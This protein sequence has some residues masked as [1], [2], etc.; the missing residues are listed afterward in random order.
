MIFAILLLFL[1]WFDTHRIL[2]E[3]EEHEKSQ[4]D[5]FQNLYAGITLETS[6][7]QSYHDDEYDFSV[8]YP[9]TLIATS[10]CCKKRYGSG[11]DYSKIVAFNDRSSGKR[12]ATLTIILPG[13]QYPSAKDRIN[14]DTKHSQIGGVDAFFS[15]YYNR[16]G[17]VHEK[18]LYMLEVPSEHGILLLEK[19]GE[20]FRFSSATLN[21]L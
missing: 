13:T 5:Y 15:A 19:M 20:T 1:N 17:F 10:T 11:S 3:F 9:E 2:Q 6:K 12:V 16:I 8:L 18:S 14:R 21:A 4:A 7:W